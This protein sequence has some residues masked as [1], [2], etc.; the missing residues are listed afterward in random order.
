M[1]AII[2]G[3][4]PVLEALRAKNREL[5]KLLISRKNTIERLKPIIELARSQNIKIIPVEQK[6]LE[7]ITGNGVHQGIVGITFEFKYATLSDILEKWHLSKTKA[8]ILILDGILDP[9]N[10]GSLI[11]TAN[12]SGVQ[13]IVIPKD[14]AAHLSPACA[15][16]SAGALEYTPVARVTN[17]A[18]TLDNLKKEG[19]WTIGAAGDAER[20]LYYPD[21]NMDLAI[22]VGNE[23]KGLRPL[24]RKKCDFLVSIPMQGDIGSLNAAVAGGIM[25][26]EVVRQ[27]LMNSNR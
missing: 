13:G 20:N 21:Y 3:I 10:L 22:V 26:F 11:R 2:Y 15:K 6:Y 23:E 18:S 24:V 7:E 17:I 27:R 4:N 19:I 25:L 5:K 14:R 1:S 8:L 9:Q 16:A 12:A